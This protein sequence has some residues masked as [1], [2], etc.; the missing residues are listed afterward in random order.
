MAALSAPTVWEPLYACASVVVVSGYLPGATIDI[1]ATPPGGAATRIGGGVSSSATGQVFG[2]VAAA[3]V[4]GVSIQATQSFGGDVSPRSP[5]VVLQSSAAIATPRLTAPLYECAHCV[6]VDRVLPGSTAEVLDAGVRIGSRAAYAASVDINVNPALA[7]GHTLTARQLVCGNPSGESTGISIVQMRDRPK[8][9]L[10]P[11]EIQEPLYACQQYVSVDGCVPGAQLQLFINGMPVS[12]ACAAGTSETLWFMAGL[13]AGAS[14]TV[15]QQ[16][17]G[18]K[19]QS[20]PSAA[21]IVRPASD[22]PRPAIR[23]PLYAGDTSVVTAMT[24]AGEIIRLDA[25]G[26]QIGSGA[27]GGGDSALNVDPPLVAGQLVT[28]TVELC[29]NKQVSLPV[30]V[31]SR[32]PVVPPPVVRKPLV[33][34]GAV[35][36]VGGCLAGARVRVSGT[37]GGDTVLI[38]LARTWSP[39]ITIGVTPLLQEG[40][41]ITATQEIGGVTSDPSDAPVVDPAPEPTPPTFSGPLYECSRCVY[42]TG[43]TPGA[44]VDVFQ[45]DVWIGGADAWVDDI[46]VGVFPPLRL[47]TIISATQSMCGKASKPVNSKA[48]KPPKELLAPKI[49]PAF[50]G[51]SYVVVSDLF[52]G[53]TVEIEEISVYNL[54][55]GRTCALHGQTSVRLNLPLFAGAV[56]RA[57]QRLC[58]ASP[59]SQSIVVGQPP[60]WPLGPGPYS[61]GFRLVHDIPLSDDIQFLGSETAG[62]GGELYR[63]ERPDQ[64]TAVIFYPATAEGEATPFAAGPFPLIVYGH[65]RRFPMSAFPIAAVCPGAPEDIEHDFLQLTGTLLQLARWGFITIAPDLSWLAVEFGIHDWQLTLQDA[66][67]YM[68]AE[69]GRNGSP[70]N[71]QV[72]P[73]NLAAMGH[74]TGGLAAIHYATSG[75]HP[76]EAL[77]LI[78]PAARSTP[79]TAQISGFAPRPAF[80]FLSGRETSFAGADNEPLA[81]YG[82]AGAVKHLATVPGGNHYGYTDA[83]CILDDNTATIPQA[84]QARVG[85][86]YL[87]AFFR[88]FLSGAL[89]VDDYLLGLRPVEELEG[90]GV[91]VE[92]E[93]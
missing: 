37:F 72:Q 46:E 78:A 93:R 1:Y 53:A 34:C 85:T 2:V 13:T 54:V 17:C 28:A 23:P 75:V 50:A 39:S 15:D 9:A 20:L 43:I 27:A 18:G 81:I 90:L 47:N 14:V 62:G 71:G 56:L 12:G 22:I 89:E 60:E 29:D 79:D 61:A 33:A 16:F 31:R 51:D 92:A 76:I 42:L 38:G 26:V 52:H 40:W 21:V 68:L 80:I 10:P 77:G 3:M 74:S 5:A 91:T 67:T 19:L 73:A 88:R 44:R 11:P 65:G 6:R 49:A 69:N 84:D 24:V 4:A 7:G 35:V 48:Q 87:T 25:D 86:A 41:I 83:L 57:R 70:F 66:V 63:F 55:V 45:D 59:Y 82:A 58:A 36:E 32:P 64:H 30:R 8:D